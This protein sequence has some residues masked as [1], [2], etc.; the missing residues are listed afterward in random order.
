[1]ND[2]TLPLASSSFGTNNANPLGMI[3]K[4]FMSDSMLRI[5]HMMNIG[6]KILIPTVKPNHIFTTL[7]N[8][9]KDVTDI[10][11]KRFHYGYSYSLQGSTRH[12]AVSILVLHMLLALI[13][14]VLL[15]RHGYT[16]N[17]LKS[18]TEILTLAINSPPFSN[19]DNTCAGIERVDTCR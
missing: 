2:M 10:H 1:M 12:L 6:F 14:A 3:A 18:L 9:P 4:T 5:L 8:V 16:N 13:R 17:I 19:R 11:I 15:F 7:S